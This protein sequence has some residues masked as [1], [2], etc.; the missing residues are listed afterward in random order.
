MTEIKA[1]QESPTIHSIGGINGIAAA[2]H[3]TAQEHGFWDDRW[4]VET[5]HSIE[6][7]V[8]GGPLAVLMLIVTEVAE[9][10]EAYRQHDRKGFGRELIDVLIRT[11]DLLAATDT[12]IDK[13]LGDVM[14]ANETRPHLHGKIC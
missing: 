7:H 14:T 13:V 4:C 5:Q 1:P 11:L 6:T 3:R 8:A 10:A 12:D 2:I 9:A